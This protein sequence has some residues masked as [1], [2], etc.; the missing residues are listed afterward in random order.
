MTASAGRAGRVLSLSLSPLFLLAPDGT[1]ASS[2][3]KAAQ[4]HTHHNPPKILLEQ[5]ADALLLPP[6]LF[7]LPSLVSRWSWALLLLWLWL[8][9][10]Y[11]NAAPA[12]SE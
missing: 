10:G 7:P 3:S 5:R 6:F 2:E 1:R 9:L 12:Q 8:S 11:S 4:T